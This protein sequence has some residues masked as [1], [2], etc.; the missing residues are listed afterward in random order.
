MNKTIAE[1]ARCLRLNVGLEKKFWVEAVNM[2]CYLINKSPRATLDRKVAEEVW[3]GSPVDY[4]SLRVFRCPTYVHIPN[5]ER[6]KFD[7]KSSQCIFLGERGER[8][9]ALGSKGK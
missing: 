1:R 8:F 9:Q 4:S 3:T 7:A 5:E 2:A 6:S